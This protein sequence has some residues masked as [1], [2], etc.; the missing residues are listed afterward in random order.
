ITY[1]TDRTNFDLR[2]AVNKKLELNADFE[3]NGNRLSLTYFNE[4]L[5]DGFRSTSNYRI[6]D[7]KKYDNT[8]VD[9]ANLTAAPLTS[10]FQSTDERQ[11]YAYTTTTNGS[12][13]NKEGVEFQFV[14]RRFPGIN[15]RFKID[16]AWFN[17]TYENT[18]PFY[19]VISTIAVTEGKTSQYIGYYND[20]DGKN[21]QQFNTNL[22]VDSDLPKLGLTL[23]SSFQ[24]LWFTSNQMAF[25]S[26]TPVSYLG[27]DGVERP[28]TEASKTDPNLNH[29]NLTHA[30]SLFRKTTVPIDLQVNFKATKRF[31]KTAAVS[32][33]V[34]RLFT[35]TPNYTNNGVTVTR[36]EFNSPYFG[37]ELNFNL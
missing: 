33:F 9:A 37:M 31:K 32:M 35:Y 18:Y 25:K 13:L 16:G 17:S 28:Y 4:K 19:K 3:L 30:A 29:L 8:S 26:G 2:A 36:Q 6:L 24:N 27:V 22:T 21:I 15:T 14:S 7:Y 10:D 23:S 12:T 20:T 1:I 11:Y 34:N 5:S